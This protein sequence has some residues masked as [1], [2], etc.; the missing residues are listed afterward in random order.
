LTGYWEP[1]S[2]IVIHVDSGESILFIPKYPPKY[3]IYAASIPTPEAVNAATGV[4]SVSVSTELSHYLEQ[5]NDAM[6]Y[7]A[8]GC[9]TRPTPTD[10]SN[11]PGAA[12]AACVIKTP[13]EIEI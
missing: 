7:S 13:C 1:S 5:Y 2:A 3:E 9:V 10:G 12:G 11:L 4:N 6:I 8:Q